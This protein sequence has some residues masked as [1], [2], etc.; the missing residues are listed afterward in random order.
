MIAEN[1]GL[2]LHQCSKSKAF[3]FGLSLHAAVVKTGMISDVLVSNHT[4]NMYAKCGN[5][6]CARQLFDEMSDRN[7][8]SW[9][10][11]ISGFNQAGKPLMALYFF[12]QM[13]LQPNEF[14]FASSISACASLLALRLGQQI[15]S[16]SLK[17]GYSFISFVANSLISMYMRCGLCNDALSVFD[18]TS[19]P[20][21]VSYNALIT[22]LVENKQPERGFQVFMLMCQRGLIPDRFTFAGVLGMCSTAEDSQRGMELHCQTIKHK[23]DSSPFVG[24]VI[25]TMYSKFNVIVDI[26]KA[27]RLIADKDVISWNTFIAACSQCDDHAK[28]LTAFR[29][30][31]TENRVRPDDFTYASAL[32]ACAGLASIHHGRQV[33]ALLIRTKLAEDVIVENALVNMYAKCG[34]IGYGYTIFNLMGCRNLVSWN[35]IIAGFANHGLG[36][37]VIELFEEMKEMGVKPDS[38]TFIGLLTACNHAGLVDLGQAYFKSMD[39]R[40]GRLDEAE[41]YMERFPFGH[42]P[43]VLGCLLSACRLHG[44]V[45]IGERLARRL[46][47]LQPVT[48]SPFVLLSNLY[49][50]DGIW[51]GV[52]E[53]RKMLKGSGLK[54]EPGHSLIEVKGIF[55]KFTIGSLCCPL[56]VVYRK[57]KLLAACLDLNITQVRLLNC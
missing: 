33:H 46:L 43:V 56:D 13:R 49:A 38:V 9:S 35:S 3:R 45:V 31:V 10:A 14:I 4:L 15:H 8:V 26:E 32:A 47:Q 24:N 28:G 5:I 36:K 50:S 42:D 20:D 12:S 17:L 11:M 40:A 1:L 7:L 48:T 16:Q 6:N 51:Y 34:C 52:A 41:G 21:S 27:F 2:L 44:D 25:M 30:M 22:G 18:T 19:A 29:E 53:A 54:K 57:L 39:R 23:L 37:K 55:E